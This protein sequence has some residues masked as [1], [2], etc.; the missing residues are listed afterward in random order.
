MKQPNN[1]DG[2]HKVIVTPY[3]SSWPAVYEKEEPL[4]TNIFK[5]TLTS[6]CHIGST[7]I[8][9][10]SAKPIID[11]LITLK[12]ISHLEPL[13]PELL[14]LGYA[15]FGEFGV[16]G[17]YFFPKGELKRT[18][19]L[20]IYE[21]KNKDLIRYIAFR[22]YLKQNSIRFKE[23]ETLKIELANTFPNDLDAYC[24]GKDILVKEIEKEALAWYTQ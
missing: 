2:N 1:L 3:N 14:K 22:E 18:H 7:S 13:I 6:I 4:L 5:E 16:P 21:K 12:K 10:L 8:P 19:H 24:D 9:G 15:Y 20:H 23:Y 11:I 17:R